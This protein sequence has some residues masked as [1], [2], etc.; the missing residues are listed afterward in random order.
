MLNLLHLVYF[1]MFGSVALYLILV[2][3]PDQKRRAR[4]RRQAVRE[5]NR[6]RAE[7]YQ[8]ETFK[9]Y[10]DTLGGSYDS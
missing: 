3:V 8:R 10:L 1:V 2:Y 6:R 7:Y 4:K 9:L 5:R